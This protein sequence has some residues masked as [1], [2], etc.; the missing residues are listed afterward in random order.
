MPVLARSAVYRP[1]PVTLSFPSYRMNGSRFSS[2][3]ATRFPSRVGY[4]TDTNGRPRTFP[5]LP[6]D[7]RGR[8]KDDPTEDARD[9][10]LGV[11]AASDPARDA[12]GGR[13]RDRA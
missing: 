1:S 5:T 10:R 7:K 3:T 8:G 6:A 9:G 2:T 13:R 11:V 12:V 4:A